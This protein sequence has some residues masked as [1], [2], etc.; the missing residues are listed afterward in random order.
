MPAQ[1]VLELLVGRVPVRVVGRRHD[2]G[3]VGVELLVFGAEPGDVVG[4]LRV[5]G[6][7][8]EDA[9][10]LGRRVRREETGDLSGG[11]GDGVLRARVTGCPQHT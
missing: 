11:G 5:F 1:E 3:Q 9:R 2:G 6:H 7:H 10:L 4:E 8:R